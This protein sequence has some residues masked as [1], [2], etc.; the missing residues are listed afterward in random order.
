[1]IINSKEAILIVDDEVTYCAVIEEILRSYGFLTYIAN[2]ASEALLLLEDTL[3]DL[4]MLDIMMPEIDGITFVRRIRSNPLWDNIPNIIASAR[5]LEEGPDS[6]GDIGANAYLSK[7]FS[8]KELRT[9]LREFLAV[10]ES[11]ILGS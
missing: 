8:A 2:N 9:V 6:V 3:P 1:L 4:I 7:P 11:G 5:P 10:P